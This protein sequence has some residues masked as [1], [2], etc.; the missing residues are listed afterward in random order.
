MRPILA[1]ALLST[2]I[3]CVSAPRGPHAEFR[4]GLAP[5]VRMAPSS[6]S[7]VLHSAGT[8]VAVRHAEKGQPV[9]FARQPDGSVAAVA[10]EF[11]LPLRGSG[12]VW[13]VP[14]AAQSWLD[15]FVEDAPGTLGFATLV[16]FG[17]LGIVALGSLLF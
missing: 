15:G 7:Y 5:M 17:L 1:L 9:G 4:E 16:G 10:P 2:T 14:P 12:Y 3:G 6:G 11:V 8:V 13:Q